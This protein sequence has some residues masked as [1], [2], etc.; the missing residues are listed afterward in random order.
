MASLAAAYPNCAIKG[1]V[2]H[3]ET[4]TS[5]TA[6]ATVMPEAKQDCAAQRLPSG[7]AFGNG[8]LQADSRRFATCSG[9]FCVEI[10]SG[11]AASGAPA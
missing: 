10:R 6:A 3:I 5:R 8:P 11:R 4:C 1:A 9:M 7:R 2:H